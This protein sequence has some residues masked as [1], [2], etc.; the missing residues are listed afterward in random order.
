M[1]GSRTSA[2]CDISSGRWVL[3][4]K[5][6]AT[7]YNESCRDIF[8][9]WNCLHNNKPNAED[10]PAWRWQPQDCNLPALN[11]TLFLDR[12]QNKRIGKQCS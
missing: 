12:F 8:K 5:R 3:D 1:E 7:A 9:G 6:R 2:R 11:A 10:I 4:K